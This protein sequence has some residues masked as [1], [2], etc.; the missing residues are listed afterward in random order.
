MDDR[1]VPGDVK[2]FVVI[3]MLSY[4]AAAVAPRKRAPLAFLVAEVRRLL[5]V[6]RVDP[7]LDNGEPIPSEFLQIFRFRRRGG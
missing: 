7:A 1:V 5:T 6:L 4:P 3:N 2:V